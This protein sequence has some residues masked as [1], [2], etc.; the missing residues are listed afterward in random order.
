MIMAAKGGGL[1]QIT[2]GD[3]L[4]LLEAEADTPRGVADGTTVFY[5][6]LHDSG[7]LGPDAPSTLR[8]LRTM[9]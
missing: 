9:S 7:V 1:A 4:E 5:R 3:V 2:V 6:V 8:P